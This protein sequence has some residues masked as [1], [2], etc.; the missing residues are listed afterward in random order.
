MPS[1]SSQQAWLPPSLWSFQVGSFIIPFPTT[2]KYLQELNQ[3]QQKDSIW[4]FEILDW[5]LQPKKKLLWNLCANKKKKKGP[6]EKNNTWQCRDHMCLNSQVKLLTNLAFTNRWNSSTMYVGRDWQKDWW[7]HTQKMANTWALVTVPSL[8]MR[9]LFCY[10]W[11][12]KVQ[13]VFFSPNLDTE[14]Y[15]TRLVSSVCPHHMAVCYM[16]LSIFVRKNSAF[17]PDQY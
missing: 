13:T 15:D 4:K 7:E 6:K 16:W 9:L 14:D 5:I 3:V 8:F 12:I 10:C 2:Y 11:L 1:F 17:S